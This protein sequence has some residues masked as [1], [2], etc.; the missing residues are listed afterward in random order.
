MK[1][2]WLEPTRTATHF[3]IARSADGVTYTSLATATASSL[4]VKERKRFE[5][6]D[7]S[8]EPG[9]VYKVTPLINDELGAAR[10]TVAPRGA[11]EVCLIIGYLSGAD[12]L[13]LVGERVRVDVAPRLRHATKVSASDTFGKREALAGVG[14]TAPLTVFVD[15]SGLWQVNLQ[16]GAICRFYIPAQDLVKYVAIPE[17]SGPFVLGDLNSVPQGSLFC[18]WPEITGEPQGRLFD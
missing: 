13:P 8:G 9:H 6:T 3:N 12:G 5:Y 4:Y 2:S 10:L 7:A 1:L 18:E 17:E 14:R 15:A 16:H 11:A